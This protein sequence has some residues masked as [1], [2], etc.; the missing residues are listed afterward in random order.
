[1]RS[2]SAPAAKPSRNAEKTATPI[3]IEWS[4]ASSQQA[5]AGSERIGSVTNGAQKRSSSSPV[6]SRPAAIDSPNTAMTEAVSAR[7]K[8]WAESI[9]GRCTSEPP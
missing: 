7:V 5:S 2:V 6:M 9:E 8:P 1:M 3:V 4:V